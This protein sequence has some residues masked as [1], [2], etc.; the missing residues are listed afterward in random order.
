M[1]STVEAFAQAANPVKFKIEAKKVS[2]TEYDIVFDASIEKGWHIYSINQTGDGPNPTHIEFN[3]SADYE[4]VGKLTES[5]PVEEMD[6]QFGIMVYTF[7]DKATFTQRIKVKTDKTF[8][9]AG[10]YEFQTCTDEM[11]TFPPAKKF[12]IDIEQ[13]G[14]PVE[15]TEAVAT[16]GTNP[17]TFKIESK[18]VS[19]TECDIIFN[20]AL[21]NGWHI[22]SVN[23]KEGPNPTHIEFNPSANYELVGKLKE[24]TPIK[25]MDKQFKAFV[26]YFENK[27][28]FTQRIKLKT[29]KPFALTG[30]FDVFQVCTEEKCEFPPAK[31][32]SLN[33]DKGIVS[34]EKT[35]VDTSTK[36]ASTATATEVKESVPETKTAETTTSETKT[37]WWL[38]FLKGIG[39]GLA[40]LITPCVFPMIPMNVS[41]FLKRN[42][43]RSGAIK[44]ALFFMLSI[45]IIYT[46]L[47]LLITAVFGETALNTIASSAAFNIFFFIML[48]IFGISFLGAFEIVLPNSWLNKI[49]S[50]SDRGGFIGIFFMATTLS[51]VSFSCTGI[52]IGNLIPLV[53]NSPT[54][55]FF[56]FLGFGFGFALP[57][58]LFAIVPSWLQSI[59]KSGGWL[60]TVKVTLGLLELALALKFASNADLVYDMHILTREVFLTLW[61]VLFGLT[62]IYLIG[63]FKLS[64]DTETPFLTI[65]RLF[66]AILAFSFTVYMVPGLWGAPLKL[67]SGVIPPSTY[68]EWKPQATSVQSSN[69]NGSS[70]LAAKM[71]NGP[72]GLKVFHNDYESALAYSKEVHKPLMIDFTG[73]A[74]ANCRKMED[75]VWVEPEIRNI[76]AN[77][78]VIV[79]LFV[80][81]RHELAQVEQKEVQWGDDKVTLETEGMKWGFMQLSKYKIS[82]QPYYVIVNDDESLLSNTGI[83]YDIGKDLPVFKTWLSN[84][85]LKYKEKHP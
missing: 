57:F 59:P 7:K 23:Q 43:K 19:D 9:L 65:P 14:A 29:D 47:G 58:G 85:I 50:Q 83:G 53:S 78:L 54:G 82:S 81:D 6:K 61:I 76:L 5:K 31:K 18:K 36:A 41:F 11:C 27:A 75:N 67:L 64:H 60:N 46:A 12:S 84:S 56:G 68:A 48:I 26:Y 77:D 25:K 8:A 17:V 52:F 37:P 55:P 63:W 40:A 35:N 1:L 3:S 70:A 33:I 2:V 24:N 39:F 69:Q 71:I 10:K 21:E 16:K 32:F 44:E 28:T 74:C 51:L 30:K 45:I 13:T 79:S 4:F 49:D 42:K 72:D 22:F 62:G 38:I 80:D 66:F 34:V 15:K 20:T 73:K